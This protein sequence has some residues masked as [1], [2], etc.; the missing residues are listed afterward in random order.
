MAA[1]HFGSGS[2]NRLLGCNT[3]IS[4]VCTDMYFCCIRVHLQCFFCLFPFFAHNIFCRFFVIL[5]IQYSSIMVDY[6]DKMLN[7]LHL[8]R[9]LHSSCDDFPCIF[10]LL[11]VYKCISYLS[12]RKLKVVM[13]RLKNIQL[14]SQSVDI[15]S[16]Y[17]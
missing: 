8:R 1:I 13:K 14:F 11:S 16:P 5:L 4:P 15:R 6:Y 17:L 2:H 7:Y 3:A 10:I 12:A 9:C